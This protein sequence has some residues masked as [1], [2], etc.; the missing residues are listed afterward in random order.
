MKI[1]VGQGS[2]GIAAGAGIAY[3]TLAAAIRDNNIDARLVSTG[4]I[5]VCY[6]EP[7]VEVTSDSGERFTYIKVSANDADEIVKKHII[8]GTPIE[9]KLIPAADKKMLES[10]TKI[11]LRNCGVIN[12][13]DIGEY[14]A[15]GGYEAA[16]KCIVQLGALDVID[17]IKESGLRGRGGAGFPAW[18]KW[19][20]AKTRPVSRNI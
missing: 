14:V 4:C 1:M 10:Q 5:G 17:I 9:D 6:L 12:P 15:V 19:D 2:C 20:A 3:D 18:F 11:A 13:E 16:R 8:G 7:I